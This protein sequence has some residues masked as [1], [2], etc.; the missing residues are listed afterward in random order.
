MRLPDRPGALLLLDL[1]EL[2]EA[3]WS[4]W[5]KDS[6]EV[7]ELLCWRDTG[8]CDEEAAV[9]PMEFTGLTDPG[10]GLWKNCPE[11]L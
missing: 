9:P 10:W 6:G 8:T 5:N 1:W 3:C 4:G 11:V 2:R 7:K